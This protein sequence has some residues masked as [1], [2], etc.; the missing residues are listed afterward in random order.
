MGVAATEDSAQWPTKA[1]SG[2]RK[3]LSAVTDFDTLRLPVEL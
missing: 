3:V 1:A 2:I